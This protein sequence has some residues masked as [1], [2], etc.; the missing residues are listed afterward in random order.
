MKNE[1][2]SPLWTEDFLKALDDVIRARGTYQQVAAE[3]W[4]NTKTAYNKL[5][6]K[7]NPDHHE[8]FNEEEVLALLRIG[9]EIECHTA[10]KHL[11]D[12]VG[13]ETPKPAAPKSPKTALAEKELALTEE[14]LKVR[15]EIDRIDAAALL[16]AAS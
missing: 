12:E 15:K 13:Y 4:P 6:N 16:R 14:L 5:K 9:R 11:C 10:I 1:H 2:Q 7:L 8:R 3:L